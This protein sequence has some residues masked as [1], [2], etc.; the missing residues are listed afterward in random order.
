M[1]YY[2]ILFYNFEIFSHIQSDYKNRMMKERFINNLNI[3]IF[4]ACVNEINFI[5]R[6]LIIYL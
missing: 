1:K 3:I 2:V 6:E 4:N 5:I